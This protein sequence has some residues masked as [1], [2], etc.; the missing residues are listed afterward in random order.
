[1]AALAA[2]L[3]R[4]TLGAL[5][6]VFGFSTLDSLAMYILML[7]ARIFSLPEVVNLYRYTPQCNLDNAQSWFTTG[8]A[9]RLPFETFSTG[10]DL[11]FSL[12]M[13]V[14]WV[15]GLTALVLAVFEWQDITA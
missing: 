6:V 10:P 1:M 3:T 9:L 2:I 12:A 4:S 11:G 13:L 8:A 14:I 5:L 15:A 7:L